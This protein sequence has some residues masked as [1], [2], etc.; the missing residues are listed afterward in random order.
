MRIKEMREFVNRNHLPTD[1]RLV[2]LGNLKDKL[3]VRD[4]PAFMERCFSETFDNYS[5]KG[6]PDYDGYILTL[7]DFLELFINETTSIPFDT[8]VFLPA[9]EEESVP[10]YWI[11]DSSIRDDDP[12][13]DKICAY[14][15]KDGLQFYL[16]I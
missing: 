14:V 13:Y 1:C 11:F 16:Q 15:L 10:T 12:F 8:C 9:R 4:V 2:F 3:C 6:L 5:M 7:K